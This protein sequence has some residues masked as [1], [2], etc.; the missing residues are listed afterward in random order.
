MATK[1]DC[2][3]AVKFVIGSEVCCHPFVGKKEKYV[4]NPIVCGLITEIIQP[5]NVATRFSGLFM[6]KVTY[7]GS[8]IDIVK[9]QIEKFSNP[10]SGSDLR[11]PEK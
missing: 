9:L 2:E 6:F 7:V 1:R 5:A 10:I 8:N 11:F 4:F 3:R